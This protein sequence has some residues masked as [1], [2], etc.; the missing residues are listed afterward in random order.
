MLIETAPRQNWNDTDLSDPTG[1]LGISGK[2]R[3]LI[4]PTMGLA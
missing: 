1:V 2:H 4:K 3:T